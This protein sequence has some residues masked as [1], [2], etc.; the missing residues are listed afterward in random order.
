MNESQIKNLKSVLKDTRVKLKTI[1]YETLFMIK[2][3]E[4]GQT[5]D[6]ATLRDCLIRIN[7]LS[8]KAF[9]KIEKQESTIDF[10]IAKEGNRA[11]EKMI[12]GKEQVG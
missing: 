12:N 1:G 7:N 9:D 4:T 8:Q 3:I 6:A 5:G 2:N 11:W 10:F